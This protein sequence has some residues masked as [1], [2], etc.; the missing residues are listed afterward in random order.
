M[1]QRFIAPPASLLGRLAAA[2]FLVP[3]GPGRPPAAAPGAPRLRAAAPRDEE[4]A[5]ARDQAAVSPHL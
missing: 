1:A 4:P 5:P 2:S 3:I